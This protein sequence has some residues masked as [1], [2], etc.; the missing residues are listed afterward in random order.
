MHR[1]YCSLAP[2]HQ[3]GG[4]LNESLNG[5]LNEIF[6]YPH[7]KGWFKSKC[8]GVFWSR[9]IHDSPGCCIKSFSDRAYLYTGL[10]IKACPGHVDLVPGYINFCGYVLTGQ[11]IFQSGH[12]LIFPAEYVSFTGLAQI[13]AGHVK[14]FAG[15]VNFQNHM[16]DGLVNQMLDVKPWYDF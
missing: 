7:R 10:D 15:H 3:Y 8:F 9:W 2:S 16:P 11:V 1:R 14:I 5:S 12:V 4:N 13:S 6:C